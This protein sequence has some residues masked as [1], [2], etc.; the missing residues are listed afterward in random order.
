MLC[1]TCPFGMWAQHVEFKWHGFYG[2]VDYAFMTNLNTKTDKVSFNSF[3]GTFG[4]QI[5]KE[6]A[7]GI[8]VSFLHDSKN[9]FT[10]IPIFL[11]LR[12]HF[13]SSRLSPF[14]AVQVGY[15]I[16]IG[17]S[18]AGPE[19]I[20]VKEGGVTFAILLGGRFA[21]T[22]TIGINAFVGYQLLHNNQVE[23]KV[24]NMLAMREPV[25]LHNLK[26]GVGINL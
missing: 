12:S 6:S 24:D 17:T 2:T 22:R 3:N 1:L 8:G 18:S 16:P 10:Q 7:V 19:A 5:R 23:R 9:A 11:E 21:I 20:S 25:L 14:S 26:I 4:W 15:T 13:L